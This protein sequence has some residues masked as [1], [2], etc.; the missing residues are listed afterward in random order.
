MEEFFRETHRRPRPCFRKPKTSSKF[1]CKVPYPPTPPVIHFLGK[2]DWGITWCRSDG[3]HGQ[4]T[5]N[6][7]YPK[8]VRSLAATESWACCVRLCKAILHFSLKKAVILKR[9][10][11]LNPSHTS[12][13]ARLKILGCNAP[14]FIYTVAPLFEDEQVSLQKPPRNHTKLMLCRCCFPFQ[15]FR[16]HPLAA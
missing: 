11:L 1:W 4:N 2:K 9:S 3:P 16:H 12:Y 8:I 6:R 14:S 15:P 13:P 7:M 10:I 5:K